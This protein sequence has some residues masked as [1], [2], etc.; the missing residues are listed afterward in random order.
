MELILYVF[1]IYDPT[2]IPNTDLFLLQNI[3]IELSNKLFQTYYTNYAL[4]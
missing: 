4:N 3:F 2:R 1:L